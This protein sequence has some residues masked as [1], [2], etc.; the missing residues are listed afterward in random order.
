MTLCSLQRGKPRRSRSTAS[1]VLAATVGLCLAAGSVSCGLRTVPPVRYAPL[2]GAEK[3]ITTALML[4]RAL[5]DRDVTVRAEAVKLLG[6]LGQSADKNT[7]KEVARVLG[8]ALR[9]VDPGLRLQA[10]E[11]LGDM[12]GEFANKYLISA[13][14]DPN[15]FV[16]T[17][18]LAVVETR[19]VKL[20]QARQPPPTPDPNALAAQVP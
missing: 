1:R 5:K 4:T 13:L 14:R 17:K 8:M 6:V 3:K 9:D 15:P 10:V 18:V 7:K 19:E 16:R 2:L 12:E 20:L 11:Q